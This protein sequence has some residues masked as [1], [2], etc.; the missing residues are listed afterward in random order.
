MSL[1]FFRLLTI[2]A[3]EAAA[4]PDAIRQMRAGTIDGIMIRG[5]YSDATCGRL[6]Q[7][8]EAGDHGLVR[9]GFP[10]AMRAYFLG[11]NLN[12]APPNLDRYFQET[13]RHRQLLHRLFEPDTDLEIRVTALFSALD[14]GR[15]YRAPPGPTTGSQHMFTTL[16]AHGTGGFIPPHFDNEQAFRDSYRFVLPLIGRDLFSFVLAFSRAEAGGTLEVFD[17][18]HGGRTFRMVDGPDDASHLALDGVPRVGF[19]LQPGE[20]ILF[21]SGHLLHRVTPVQGGTTRWTACS[22]MAESREGDQVFCWG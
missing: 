13:G 3:A 14:G 8:L 2:D 9:M 18:H 22:F 11:I 4:H 1:S 12:L 19:R 21:N 17:L 7:A 6:C 5:V 15:A 10:A 16:R 20:M